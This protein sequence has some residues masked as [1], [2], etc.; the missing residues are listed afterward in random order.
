P[1]P[2]V[3]RKV[4]SGDVALE[5]PATEIK[6][7]IYEPT[8]LDRPGM[9]LIEAKRKTT[10]DKQRSLVQTTKD[11]VAKQA[12]AAILAT[13][14]YLE[15]KNES[16]DKARDKYKEARDLLRDVA[17]QVGDKAIDEIT[18]R[19]LGSYEIILAADEKRAEEQKKGYA[20]AEKAWAD[21]IDKDPK[22]KDVPES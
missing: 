12:Q 15:T 18:L 22:A 14:L 3:T 6:G 2:P 5:L 13:M 4:T 10:K 20:A 11:P 1:N 17:Q 16:P 9:P 8:A 21:L 7:V 19:L